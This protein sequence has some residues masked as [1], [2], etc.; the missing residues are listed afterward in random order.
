MSREHLAIVTADPFPFQTRSL[1]G[2]RL[3]DDRGEHRAEH[4]HQGD[5]EG[6]PFCT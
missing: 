6:P 2:E 4:V 3:E 1:R 5:C